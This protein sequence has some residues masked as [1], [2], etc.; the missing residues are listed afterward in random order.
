ML[1]PQALLAQCNKKYSGAWRLADEFRADRGNTISDWPEWCFLPLAGWYAI[2]C[3]LLDRDFLSPDDIAI[4]HNLAAIGAWRPS[5][6][7]F[8]F[9]SEIYESI[10]HTELSGD[11]PGE[12]LLHLPAWCIYIALQG[13]NAPDAWVHLEQDANDGRNELRLLFLWPDGETT[14]FPLHI[15]KFS[16]NESL[17]RVM[18]EVNKNTGMNVKELCH[19]T[20]SPHDIFEWMRLTLNLTLYL[21]SD[22]VAWPE[23][24]SSGPS[25]PTP[26]KTAKGIRLYPPSSPRI[27]YI[28][29][30]IGRTIRTYR[31]GSSRE[32]HHSSPSPHIRRAH[33]HGFWSGTIKVKE[34][35]EPVPREFKLRWLPPIPVAMNGEDEK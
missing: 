15:G 27:W 24:G 32:N 6:D 3:E 25:K 14:G 34:G 12:I 20:A 33:W 28:G 4:M 10:A 7:I 19:D 30:E 22:S 1:K 2:T 23:A 29:E 18:N 26:K 8:C 21:C 13:D 11:I 17:R 9:D 5:Q 35:I 16:L 31:E